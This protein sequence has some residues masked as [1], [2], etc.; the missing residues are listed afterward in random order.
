MPEIYTANDLIRYIYKETTAEENLH[1]RHLLNHN[2]AAREEF[3]AFTEITC[4]LNSN[5]INAHP[6]SIQLVLEHSL[7]QAAELI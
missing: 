7:K 6:T 3:D 5:A 1:I 4:A 2:V